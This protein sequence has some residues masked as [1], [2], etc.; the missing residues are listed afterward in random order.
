MVAATWDML[1]SK[2]LPTLIAAPTPAV[3]APVPAVIAVADAFKTVD[4]AFF[5]MPP[6]DAIPLFNLEVSS[7]VSKTSVPSAMS[8]ATFLS[9]SGS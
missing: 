4:A 3:I 9:G 8:H 6:T 7:F 1:A 2:L 5:A